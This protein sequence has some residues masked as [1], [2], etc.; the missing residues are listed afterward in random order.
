[1]NQIHVLLL[2]LMFISSDSGQDK[3]AQNGSASEGT[4]SRPKAGPPGQQTTTGSSVFYSDPLPKPQISQYVRR[5]FQDRNGNIWF[6]TNGDGVARYDARLNDSARL[7]K[8]LA[9]FTVNEGF[10]GRA[11]RGIVEDKNGD[12]WFATD[13]GISRY[14]GRAFE[15]FDRKNGL[16]SNQVWSILIDRSGTVWCGTEAGVYK[17]D[18]KSKING[19]PAFTPFPLPEADLSNRPDAYPAPKLVNSI[20]QDKAGNLWFGTN[21]LGVYRYDGTSSPDG[22]PRLTNFS[23][24]EGLSNN[25]VQSIVQDESK[26]EH[27]GKLWF[28][29]RFGG[30]SRFDGVRFTNFTTKEGLSSNFVWTFLQDN[31]GDNPNGDLWIGSA[32][33]GLMLYD[34]KSFRHFT[35]VEGLP[36]RHVQS[37][38]KDDNGR[39]WVGTSG[40][41]F[42]LD[43][44]SFTNVTR[45]GPW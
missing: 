39:L 13:A 32:G 1:M 35:Q 8:P 30:I 9:Y 45:Y 24:K 43:G 36:S 22:K 6:G 2:T 4:V 18:R 7:D 44:K 23:E 31:S 38:L 10:S 17:N 3:I 33:G 25:F 19:L 5:I 16:G 42:R 11:V 21:G 12:L 40:G 27:K 41:A 26:G 29:T 34:G 37:L 14:D 20:Y 28:G 15:T